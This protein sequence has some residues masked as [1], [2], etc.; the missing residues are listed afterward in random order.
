MKNI[1]KSQLMTDN[2]AGLQIKKMYYEGNLRNFSFV[3][4]TCVAY[5]V[6]GCLVGYAFKAWNQNGSFISFLPS[7][8]VG[9]L[10]GVVIYSGVAFVIR[11][12]SFR[13]LNKVENLLAQL[14]ITDPREDLSNESEFYTKLIQINF[15]YTDQYY[16]QTQEQ[17]DKSFKLS[18]FASVAGLL[19]IIFGIYMM[20]NETG[21]SN[22]PSYL[23]TASG[24]LTEFISAIFFFLYSKTV[25]K[26]SQYHKNLLV[27]QNI[28]LALKVVDKLEPDFKE[29]SLKK[30][31]DRLTGELN[32]YLYEK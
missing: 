6:S 12:I 3:W 11:N 29:E 19:I 8:I 7:I 27:T 20:Y 28:N 17:A 16:L 30:I 22:L 4:W 31:I 24:I 5:L 18:A 15:K 14:G 1:L 32:K 25:Q 10:I 21:D 2:R 9:G 26:M 23:T 13:K